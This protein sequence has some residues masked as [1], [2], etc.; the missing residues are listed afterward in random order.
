ME[1]SEQFQQGW[2]NASKACVE[3]LHDEAKRMNDP[4]ARQVLNDAAFHLDAYISTAPRDGTAI[5]IARA[6]PAGGL[7]VEICWWAGA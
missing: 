3:W 7:C 1:R 5:L 2:R 4:H 6:H